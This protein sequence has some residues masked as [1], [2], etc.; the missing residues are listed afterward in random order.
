MKRYVFYET[1]GLKVVSIEYCSVLCS[2]GL[3]FGEE[4]GAGVDF[5]EEDDIWEGG[6]F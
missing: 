1:P 3:T 4:G 2:S 5:F 6:S